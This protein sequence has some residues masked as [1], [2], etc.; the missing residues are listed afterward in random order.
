MNSQDWIKKLELLPHPEGGY[1]KEV[2]RAT[3]GGYASEKGLRSYGTGIYFLLESRHFSAFHRIDAD[4]LWHFYAGSSVKIYILHPSGVLEEKIN[5]SNPDEEAH[6]QV[7]IPAGCWFAAAVIA[8]DSY[9][10]VGCTVAP[11]FEFEGFELAHKKELL[12][13]YPQHKTIIEK[14]ALD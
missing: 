1:Y 9:A 11:G 5:G 13:K 3:E 2:Y 12:E 10:L 6:F 7:V 8:A 4:E 14:Y